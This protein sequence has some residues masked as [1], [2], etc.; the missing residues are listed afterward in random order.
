[1]NKEKHINKGVL[2]NALDDCFKQIYYLVETRNRV[3]KI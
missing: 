3:I 2:H 1:M